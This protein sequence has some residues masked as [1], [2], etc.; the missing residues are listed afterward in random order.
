MFQVGELVRGKG[1]YYSVTTEKSLCEV[2]EILDS[3]TI[4]VKV[5]A[6]TTERFLND[7]YIV[8]AQEFKSCTL[9]EF[10]SVYPDA[11]YLEQNEIKYNKKENKKMEL[12]M[13]KETLGSYVLTTEERETLRTE[14]MDLLGEYDY[15]PTEEAVDKILN[16]WVRNKGWMINLFKKHP[17]YNG[18]FQIAFDAD[19]T[20]CTNKETLSIFANW[21]YCAAEPLLRVPVNKGA[22]SYDEV[23]RTLS[24][25]KG[26][27]ACMRDIKEV[28]YVPI[29]NGR[30]YEETLVEKDKWEKIQF[31]YRTD[32]NLY[33]TGGVAYDKGKWNTYSYLYAFC[34]YLKSYTDHIATE[35]FAE[36]VNEHFPNVKAVAGQKVSRIV[37]KLCKLI[38]IDKSLNY[39]R[40]FAKYSDA[41][42]PLAIKRHTILSCHPVD[43]LTMSFGNSW[44]SCHTIDKQNK[45]NM[46]NDYSGCYS[47]GT[48]SYML[49][50]S[51]FVYYTVDKSYEG[52]EYELQ[53]KINR[54]MF[55]MG[56]DK[57]IQARVYPQATDGDSGIYKQIREIAQ[58]VIADCLGVPNMWKN[59][60]GSGECGSMIYSYGT[61]YR[62][63]TNFSD[64][65]VSY[66]KGETD[67]VNRKGIYVGHDPICPNC[68]RQ[69]DY[70]EAI[71]CRNCYENTRTCSCC[72]RSYDEE[73]MH[74][75]NGEW[76]CEGCS[77]YCEYHEEWEADDCIYV[78]NYGNVCEDALDYG[79]YFYQCAHCDLWHY[80]ESRYDHRIV[81][82]DGTIFCGRG[83]AE[84]EDYVDLD[85]CWYHEDDVCYCEHCNTTVHRDNWN[86]EL[87]CCEDCEDEVREEM[88][89]TTDTEGTEEVEEREAV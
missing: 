57:L 29:V 4:E 54:N 72:G 81:T 60:K 16:E 36:R 9:E 64:C 53:D 41:I 3:S 2:V 67:E 38:G 20:R 50:E 55:H 5:V 76:Y 10:L 74:Y 61:H 30:T 47:S 62:D 7:T 80:S 24:K 65:N 35:E 45:R 8:F 66:L 37:N 27:L 15:N 86:D 12:R 17:N 42:N 88:E 75:I 22:F 56:E 85:G 83:C 82:E 14:I 23:R 59:V 46:P 78:E 87:D 11:A 18:K 89:A 19:Y 70:Q 28:G 26:V 71:E 49:D 40:E 44:A 6:H 77:F 43:Y 51:S 48:L 68:G 31:Q 69:H 39:N 25:L 63:Y 33:I 13:N 1:H 34:C 84:A 58:K 79:E 73:E 32:E 21:M 52:N